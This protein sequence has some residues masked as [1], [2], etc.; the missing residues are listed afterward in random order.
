MMTRRARFLS[1]ALVTSMFTGVLPA[2]EKPDTPSTVPTARA[3]AEMA[4]AANNFW[5]SLTPEQQEKA[6]FKFEDDQR[7]DWHF[8]PKARKG[9]TI[10][11]MTPAQRDLAYA[12][13]SSGVSHKGFMQ[14]VTI[15]SLDEILKTVENGKG[16]LRDP[17]NYFFSVF[18]KP[19]GS[20]PWG[21]RV[22]GHHLSLN[23]TIVDGKAVGVG[24]A[25]FGSNP[26]E[27]R[28]GP[29]K[30]L[31]ILGPEEDLGR[32]L[33]KSLNDEQK[34]AAIY[35]ATAPKD[36][37]SFNALHAMRNEEGGIAYAK[38]DEG[39][40]KALVELVRDYADRM[41]GD[42]AA[43]D[44]ARITAAG[45]DNVKFAWAGG[46]ERGE[47][48]YYRVQGPTFLIEYDNTQNNA[49]HVHSVWRDMTRDWGEDLLGKH[50]AEIPHPDAKK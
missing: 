45:W 36:I 21:W 9:L 35:T 32:A 3:V 28:E 43:D 48:H 31:R 46:V 26:A 27:V 6:G 24:P 34:K 39:Q 1:L 4:E 22:E 2:R 49:N 10:K 42:V 13:L 19:G 25:F 47:G 18:G 41:R 17:E 8:I 14:A 7:L 20:E 50:Y 29:R 15:M 5:V 12:F 37:I 30:G 16:P 33:V 38:L 44:F 23:F 11:E 40:K